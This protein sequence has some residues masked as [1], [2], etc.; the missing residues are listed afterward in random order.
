LCLQWQRKEN[1]SSRSKSS[2]RRDG[3]S[4]SISATLGTFFSGLF[5]FF[6]RAQEDDL[7]V[8]S[9]CR[10]LPSI[11]CEASTLAGIPNWST[12]CADRAPSASFSPCYAHWSWSLGHP[13][14]AS[15]HCCCGYLLSS[16]APCLQQLLHDNQNK[17]RRTVCKVAKKQAEQ[18]YVCVRSCLPSWSKSFANWMLDR[19]NCKTYFVP[20]RDRLNRSLTV[21][22]T[23]NVHRG[24]LVST[25]RVTEANRPREEEEE[26][27][28]T[29]TAAMRQFRHK[30]TQSSHATTLIE[31]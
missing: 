16:S 8:Q 20:V 14:L 12:W 27:W 24:R 7:P 29:T 17:K 18:V 9:R 26:E 1:T 25:E 28:Q 22:V 6:D 3:D 31:L 15:H 4:C 23:Q 13:D 11:E 19:S 10:F 30:H 5:P 2:R 21:V